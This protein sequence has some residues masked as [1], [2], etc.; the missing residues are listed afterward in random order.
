MK[1]GRMPHLMDGDRVAACD[2][3]QKNQWA[4]EVHLGPKLQAMMSLQHT[5]LLTIFATNLRGEVTTV[6]MVAAVALELRWL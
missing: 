3:H 2:L 6:L 1:I 5:D 4:R